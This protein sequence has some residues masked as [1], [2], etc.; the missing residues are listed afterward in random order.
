MIQMPNTISNDKY[1]CC[2]CGNELSTS[3]FF[4]SSSSIF[5]GIGHLPICKDCLERDYKKYKIAYHGDINRA[6]QRICMMFDIYYDATL[7]NSCDGNDEKAVG[8]YMRKTNLGQYKNRTF[9]TSIDEGFIFID[10]NTLDPDE[11]TTIENPPNPK[12]VDKWG[13]GL[14]NIDYDE[15]EKHYKYLKSANPNCDSNQEIFIVEL[16]Y[17]KM[18]QMKAVREGRVDDYKKLADS[19]RQ[20]FSQAGLKTVRD[21]SAAESFTI[22]INAETIEKYTP[23]EYYKNKQLYKDHDNIQDYIERFLLR[24]LRNLKYGSTDRDHEF[25]VKDEGDDND[26]IDDE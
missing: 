22:G 7:F 17:T 11:K 13:G 25:Y 5:A 16:C 24:P 10:G 26:F 18:Q 21:T 3:K 2:E 14:S 6:M 19:Y 4:K 9:D 12:Y 20:S 8:N 23:A 1:I 15:L